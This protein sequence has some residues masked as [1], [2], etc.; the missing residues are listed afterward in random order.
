MLYADLEEKSTP[1]FAPGQTLQLA[2]PPNAQTQ[3]QPQGMVAGGRVGGF[4]SIGVAA[5]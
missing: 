5:M 4:Q 1:V 3:H 2:Q